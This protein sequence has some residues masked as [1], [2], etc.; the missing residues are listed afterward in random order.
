MGQ[1]EKQ[2]VVKVVDAKG[3]EQLGRGRGQNFT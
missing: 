2:V 1:M 3:G